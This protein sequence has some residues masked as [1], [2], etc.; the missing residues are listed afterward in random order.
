[1]LSSRSFYLPGAYDAAGGRMHG[2]MYVE[3][4]RGEAGRPWPVVMIHGGGQTGSCFT[5]K[6]DGGGGWAQAFA[7]RGFASYVID[8]PARGRSPYDPEADGPLQPVFAA[9]TAERVFTAAARHRLWPSAEKHD[10]W[11][12]PGTPGDPIFDRFYASQVP[13]RRDHA[14][15]EQAA[16]E[17]IVALL[18]EIGPAILIAHSQGCPRGW[19]VADAV[20]DLVKGLVAVEPMGRPFCWTVEL[21]KAFGIPPDTLC[22]PFGLCIGPLTYD[23]PTDD[24]DERLRWRAPE[25]RGR[26]RLPNLAHVPIAIVSADAS[27]HRNSDLE[28]AEFLTAMGVENRLLK[29][30]EL[31]LAGNGHMMMLE[32]NSDAIAAAL[33]TQI[34]AWGL[35]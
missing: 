19:R 15:M 16:M 27:Y 7:R 3:L 25:N 6:P 5:V 1:V 31:G 14:A 10:Q 4:W 13:M 21:A 35:G 17:A 11:P 18:R 8:E 26:R 9:E 34:E 24:M 33:V 22:H 2:A 23:P 20:P 32:R 28:I 30:E 12:G 29:L